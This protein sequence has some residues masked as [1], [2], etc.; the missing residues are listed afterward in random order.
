MGFFEFP[1]SRTYDTDLGWLIR[2]VQKYN[3]DIA[4][5]KNWSLTH[6]REYQQLLAT[7]E[8]LT[9]SLTDPVEPWNGTIEYK[10]YSMVTY[11]NETYIAIRDVPAGI[12]ITDD[13]YWVLANTIQEQ[14]GAIIDSVRDIESVMP[15]DAVTTLQYMT[16]GDLGGTYCRIPFVEHSNNA[17]L[18]GG[19]I[20]QSN[21]SDLVPI[22]IAVARSTDNGETWTRQIVLTRPQS[23]AN[24]RVMDG[25][26]AVDRYNNRV[27]VFGHLIDSDSAWESQT[28]PGIYTDC[29]YRYSDDDGAT[30]SEQLSLR[31][32]LGNG[33]GNIIT[34]FAGVGK[35]IY[36]SD[37]RLVI[38][39]VEKNTAS[40]TVGIFYTTN[41]GNTWIKSNNIGA[42]GNEPQLVE[43]DGYLYM[44]VRN[45]S[46]S[47]DVYRT[48][49]YGET[50]EFMPQ[51]SILIQPTAGVCCGFDAYDQRFGK[52]F[53]YSGCDYRTSRAE[54][55]IKQSR[56]LY[57]WTNVYKLRA[58][59]DGANGYT[60]LCNYGNIIYCVS[61]Y[62]GNLLV[63]MLPKASVTLS[64]S[65]SLYSI[66]GTA[67]RPAD[68][69]NYVHPGMYTV[70][71]TAT[72]TT[73]AN[74][75]RG[76]GGM[77]YVEARPWNLQ[78]YQRY[79]T[80]N[81]FSYERTYL[82]GSG[83]SAWTP[84]R[85]LTLG[86]IENG[87]ITGNNMFS[88]ETVVTAPTTT[89]NQSEYK[90]YGPFVNFY[91]RG[92]ITTKGSGSSL[93]FQLPWTAQNRCAGYV[94]SSNGTR[95]ENFISGN[96]VFIRTDRFAA[97]NS[98]AITDNQEF[99]ISGS[100]MVDD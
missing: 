18:C 86:A 95:Y 33:T 41:H 80:F 98:D 30:W 96:K 65:P 79:T 67:D 6:N 52:I 82:Y 8:A 61:E 2:E 45:T 88:Y 83:G 68:L 11:E 100:I 13:N 28:V 42:Y 94:Q 23:F 5:L 21:A 40:L 93:T 31:S 35:G 84:W 66:N 58:A 70:D 9:N 19:D 75:P 17:L 24:S 48:G 62:A 12:L 57:T 78:V 44:T 39:Y 29:V 27:Y 91:W 59:A 20:R 43:Y 69:N 63:T 36:T 15:L 50:W 85:R 89:T 25:C 14:L 97:L 49:N 46:G 76:V 87:S 53:I 99:I 34:C 92:R 54:L 38:P 73:G 26:I 60:S 72:A 55:T 77:L 47:C 64:D 90:K 37:D 10:I 1:H 16:A 4:A 71:T 74:F 22:N 3:G 51:M 32:V 81:G 56:D 7:V